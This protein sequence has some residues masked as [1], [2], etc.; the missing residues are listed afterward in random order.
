MIVLQG[1]EANGVAHSPVGENNVAN[2]G[3]SNAGG[4]GSKGMTLGE[5]VDHIVT[6]D[7]A[8]P[9]SSYRPYQG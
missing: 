8:P 7:F 9:L 1:L 2:S 5:H 6:K 3:S 4:G